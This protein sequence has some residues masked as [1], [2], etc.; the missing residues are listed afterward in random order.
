MSDE[1]ESSGWGFVLFI[2]V[3][4]FGAQVG[5]IVGARMEATEIERD[6]LLYPLV[7]IHGTTFKC[8]KE[9]SN[10]RIQED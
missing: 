7:V 1:K 8:E 9:K 6:C 2:V 5:T 10:E 3:F 4:I